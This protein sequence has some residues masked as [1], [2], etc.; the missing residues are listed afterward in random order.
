MYKLRQ[1]LYLPHPTHIHAAR[2]SSNKAILNL[3]PVSREDL[4]CGS[5]WGHAAWQLGC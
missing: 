1:M 5:N 2:L 3:Y 4:K